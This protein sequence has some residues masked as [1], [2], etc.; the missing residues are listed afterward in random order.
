[1]SW[2]TRF[3]LA[4][5][6]LWAVQIPLAI[7]TDLK[8]SVSYLVFLSVAALIESAGTDFDQARQQDKEKTP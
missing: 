2:R 7:L 6:C 3:H 5:L 8:Q 4:R 1:M